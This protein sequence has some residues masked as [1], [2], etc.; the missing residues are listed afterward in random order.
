MDFKYR[1]ILEKLG[2]VAVDNNIYPK[3][4]I[5]GSEIT[6]LSEPYQR[7]FNGISYFEVAI[8]CSNDAAWHQYN[9]NA[10]YKQ[11]KEA[12]KAYCLAHKTCIGARFRVV[13]MRKVTTNDRVLVRPIFELI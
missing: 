9:F 11:Q 6:L 10:L 8:E 1:E 4:F 5:V 13:E 3:P 12:I 2:K 7:E